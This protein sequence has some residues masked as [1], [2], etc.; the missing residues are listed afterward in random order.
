MWL[1]RNFVHP[2]IERDR[3][4]FELARRGVDLEFLFGNPTNSRET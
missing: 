4:E 3:L 2:R 1:R